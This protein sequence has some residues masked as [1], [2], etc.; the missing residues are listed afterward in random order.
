MYEFSESA[1]VISDR[2]ITVPFMDWRADEVLAMAEGGVLASTVRRRSR[3]VWSD[4]IARGGHESI[5]R[6]VL[7]GRAQALME[8]KGVRAEL[9]D[10]KKMVADEHHCWVQTN[11]QLI[12]LTNA[13]IDGVWNHSDAGCESGRRTFLNSVG[14]DDKDIDAV[15]MPEMPEYVSIKVTFAPQWDNIDPDYRTN[16]DSWAEQLAAEVQS[17]LDASDVVTHRSAYVNTVT[18]EGDAPCQIT[19]DSFDGF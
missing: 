13:V 11:Q 14:I 4:T 17:V 15:I 9:E 6:D 19:A 8:L 18:N 1:D 2:L 12:D 5:L 10:A 16:P 7:E 3:M